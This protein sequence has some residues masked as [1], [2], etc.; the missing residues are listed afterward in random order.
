MV[1]TSSDL[2]AHP[3]VAWDIALALRVASP[4][5]HDAILP[6]CDGVEITP[7]N[8]RAN[9]KVAGNIALALIVVSPRTHDSILPKCD[10]V[11]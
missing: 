9:P 7:G 3:K 8:F 1:V 6:K 2:R 10:G 5:A 4:R 11:G